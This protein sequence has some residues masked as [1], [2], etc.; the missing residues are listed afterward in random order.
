MRRYE[1]KDPLLVLLRREE[2]KISKAKRKLKLER[3]KRYRKF[4]NRGR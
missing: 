1:F 4:D 2:E 3:E